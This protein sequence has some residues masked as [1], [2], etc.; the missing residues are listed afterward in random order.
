MLGHLERRIGSFGPGEIGQP[1][2]R[3][4]CSG[5]LAGHLGCSAKHRRRGHLE[6]GFHH[7]LHRAGK[8]FL[9]LRIGERAGGAGNFAVARVR[10]R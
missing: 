2:I 9:S 5:I 10:R 7:R 6:H 8:L 3:I 4:D 1:L